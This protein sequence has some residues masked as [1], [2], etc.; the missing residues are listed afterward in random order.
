MA[1]IISVLD[2]QLALG[3]EQY[4]RPMAW[5]ANWQK[6]RIGIRCNIYGSQAL[7][8][9]DTGIELGV[10][11]QS[12]QYNDAN[13]DMVYYRWGG[14]LYG[15][16]WNPNGDTG[17]F[18]FNVRR[19][20]VMSKVGGTVNNVTQ[21]SPSGGYPIGGPGNLYLFLV[22]VTRNGSTFDLALWM[23][24]TVGFWNASIYDLYAAMQYDTIPNVISNP[25]PLLDYV[26]YG[27]ANYAG[28][29]LLDTVWLGW[30]TVV[31]SIPLCV[32]EIMVSR[33]R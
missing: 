9:T 24:S 5:G 7:P 21:D 30:R 33:F 6:I 26:R 1:Q 10:C 18:G 29:G 28:S 13:A 14:Q 3:R 11:R 4:L 19:T 17:Y 12:I 8:D 2:K 25:V 20:D 32:S 31:P 22:D 27:T 16:G 23:N 15:M